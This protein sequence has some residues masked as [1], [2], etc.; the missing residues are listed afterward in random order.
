[1]TRHVSIIR[2]VDNRADVRISKKCFTVSRRETKEGPDLCPV[3]LI[4][5]ALGS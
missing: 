2:L 5:A 4:I 1:M 3:E